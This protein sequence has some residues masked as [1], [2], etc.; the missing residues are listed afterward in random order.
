MT[1]LRSTKGEK[2]QQDLFNALIRGDVENLKSVIRS[3]A[4]KYLNKTL[5]LTGYT[6]TFQKGLHITPYFKQTYSDF[7]FRV[8]ICSQVLL[9]RNIIPFDC[10]LC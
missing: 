9:G 3:G 2:K 7:F 6:N 1:K 8:R 5:V 10:F 4:S